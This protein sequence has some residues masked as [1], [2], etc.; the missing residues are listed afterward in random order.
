MAEPDK[1]VL[2]LGGG[3]QSSA[4][5][6]MSAN[7]QLPRVDA[8]VFADTQGEL[9]ETYE[10]LDYLAAQLAAAE[11]PLI[12]ITAG[13]LEDALLAPEPTPENP[14]PPAHVLRPDGGKGRIGAYRC[15]W[16]F[17]RSVITRA[18]KQLV[19]GR[20]AWKRATVEQWI[21][22]S[23][24]ELSRCKPD[25]ECRCGHNR[26]RP[27]YKTG[28]KAGE[29]RGHFPGRGCTDCDCA[30]FDPWRINRWPLVEAG[31]RRGDTIRWFTTNGHPVPPRSACW[32]CPNSGNARWAELRD[33]HPDLWE[34]AC[35][36][37][38]HIR[39]G[40]SFNL[41]GQ[42]PFQ[43]QM[44]LHGSLIP[45]RD[46]DLR[47]SH[48]RAQASG[49]GLLWAEDELAHDCEAGVCFT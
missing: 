8:V 34:R 14:T 42:Q 44:F 28:P 20:G 7:G 35:S 3:S 46:A 10:Y 12:R 36:L 38:E 31:M 37:D 49:Q 30:A 11:I 9:P 47:T 32:F 6:L 2:S 23:T 33:T 26:T 43:G 39:N 4:L 22:M 41:R 45:L 15:S 29:P 16:D 27:P 13:S 40:G 19:G 48:E 25:P 5:A 18:T 1:V 21:G 17:K 24:D